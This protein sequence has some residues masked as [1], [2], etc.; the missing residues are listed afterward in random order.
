MIR[1]E[2]A[3]EGNGWRQASKERK[4]SWVLG[5]S[6][7][8]ERG[9]EDSWEQRRG[10]ELNGLKEVYWEGAVVA[11]VSCEPEEAQGKAE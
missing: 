5:T 11:P 7:E 1:Q 9:R 8:G 10:L 4:P 6:V 2:N 3:K